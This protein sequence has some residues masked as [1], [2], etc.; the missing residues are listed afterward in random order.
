MKKP[1]I[2]TI[3]V[4]IVIIMLT[5]CVAIFLGLNQKKEAI[6]AY[7]FQSIMKS[8]GYIVQDVKEQVEDYDYVK[9][10]Y[11]AINDDYSYQIEFY[12]FSDDSD[13]KDFFD[14]NKSIFETSK[15]NSSA[16]TSKAL[17]NYSKYTL[18]TDGEYKVLSRID[19]TAVYID[20]DK[21][22][23]DEINSVLKEL[24]Y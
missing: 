5:F 9:Q 1:V 10:V 21:E 13:S 19:N 7:D 15:G 12:E 3:V 16:E 8:K 24:G 6:S 23:K 17:K 18:S 2:I 11:L 20:V 14:Y 4:C 22:Y